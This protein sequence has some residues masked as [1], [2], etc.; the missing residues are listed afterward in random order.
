MVSELRHHIIDR[1]GSEPEHLDEVL[2]TFRYVK[3]KRNEVILKQGEICKYVY[4]VS[5]GCLQVFVYDKE[6]NERPVIS[7]QKTTGAPN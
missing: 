3:L 4:F 5:S 6:M 7:L 2:A 1:L